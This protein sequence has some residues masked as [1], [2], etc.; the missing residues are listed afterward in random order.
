MKLSDVLI[1]IGGLGMAAALG[2]LLGDGWASQALL[3]LAGGA[4]AGFVGERI[5]DR[6]KRGGGGTTRWPGRKVRP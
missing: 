5:K 3:P 2:A 4:V 1:V 6:G